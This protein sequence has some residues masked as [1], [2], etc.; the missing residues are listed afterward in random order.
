MA[1]MTAPIKAKSE[2]Q[3]SL[4]APEVEDE[5]RWTVSD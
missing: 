4:A 5:A 1:S 2:V 3:T